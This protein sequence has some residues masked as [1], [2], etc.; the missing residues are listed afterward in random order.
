MDVNPIP[1]DGIP[2]VA[3]Q[4]AES[5]PQAGIYAGETLGY[6]CGRCHQSDET[7][8]QVVHEEDCELSG[9]HGR[10][11]YGQKLDVPSF[12]HASRG[13]LLPKTEFSQLKWGGS[14]PQ[15]G[16]YH[17]SVVAFRCDDCG[18]VDEHIFEVS[19]DE[20]CPIGDLPE[21]KPATA[22]GTRGPREV[23]HVNR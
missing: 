9:E 22:G 3:M 8:E 4:A 18:N 21:E 1:L 12:D 14:L 13:E 7:L 10:N 16:I 19:H 20:V 5:D 11:V 6:F 23:G 15:F 17:D 2:M